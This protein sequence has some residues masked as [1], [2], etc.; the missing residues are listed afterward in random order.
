MYKQRSFPFHLAKGA[1]V[2]LCRPAVSVSLAGLMK[3]TM[4]ILTLNLRRIGLVLFRRVNSD[5]TEKSLVIY[6]Y[7]STRNRYDRGPNN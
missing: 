2:F 1:S 6:K 7:D 3:R 5:V 4:R